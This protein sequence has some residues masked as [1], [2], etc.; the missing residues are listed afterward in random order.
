MPL[1]RILADKMRPIVTDIGAVRSHS[2]L[3]FLC[4]FTSTSGMPW[5]WSLVFGDSR[6]GFEALVYF[7]AKSLAKYSC[8]VFWVDKCKRRFG[9]CASYETHFTALAVVGCFLPELGC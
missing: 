1:V 9:R 5:K 7:R 4:G 6:H 3:R 2:C 8:G